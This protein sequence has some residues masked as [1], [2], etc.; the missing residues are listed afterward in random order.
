MTRVEIKQGG[1]LCPALV[2]T[3]LISM[4]L[5]VHFIS[6]GI[7]LVGPLMKVRY[8]TGSYRA[9]VEALCRVTVYFT[10]IAY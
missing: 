10:R 5:K 6:D 4:T 7:H 3:I 8:N 1:R 2:L 9:S